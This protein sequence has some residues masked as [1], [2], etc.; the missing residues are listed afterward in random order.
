MTENSTIEGAQIV[1]SE[2]ARGE[3]R[4]GAGIEGL[5]EADLDRP[6]RIKAVREGDVASI[7]S[8]ELVTA[9]DGPGTRLT[10]FFNGCPLR[11]LYCH[12]PDTFEMRNG[13][14]VSIEEIIGK[15][16]RYRSVF[17]SL[18]HI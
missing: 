2:S 12:N 1:E 10:V 18:I 6:D 7:H 3:R 16:K 5:S 13:R 17:L 15:V 14:D 11:C 8:W 9:V 4:M